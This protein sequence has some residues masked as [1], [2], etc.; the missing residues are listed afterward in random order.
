ML[1]KIIE[2]NRIKSMNQIANQYIRITRGKGMA[3]IKA[4]KKSIPKVVTSR[5]YIITSNGNLKE[6]INYKKPKQAKRHA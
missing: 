1:F 4:T 2:S 6:V 3:S 5:V